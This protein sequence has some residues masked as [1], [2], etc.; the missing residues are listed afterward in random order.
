MKL[1]L[2]TVGD[3]FV[4]VELDATC[5]TRWLGTARAGDKVWDYLSR[6]APDAGA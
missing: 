4:T 6:A 1:V 2:D 3:G 5:L